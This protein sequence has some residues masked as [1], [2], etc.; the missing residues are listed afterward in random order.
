MTTKQEIENMRID[1]VEQLCELVEKIGY[2]GN[3]LYFGSGACI[4][5][6]IEFFNDNPGAI[7]AVQ[8]FIAENAEAYGLD[9]NE[10]C[11]GCGCLPGDGISDDCEDEDGCGHWKKG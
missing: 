10:A 7:E 9:D 5:S 4:G 3:Q 8:Q 1:T 2:K 11:P 6:L